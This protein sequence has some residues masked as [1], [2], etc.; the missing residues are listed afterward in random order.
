M[1]SCTLQTQMERIDRIMESCTVCSHRGKGLTESW[2]AVHYGHRWK[3]LTESWRAVQYGD[4]A[5]KGREIQ[6]R[7]PDIQIDKQ[8]ERQAERQVDR[9]AD[10]QKSG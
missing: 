8:T 3:G 1:E 10:R 4:T 9:K 2:R 6:R 7:P 5:G